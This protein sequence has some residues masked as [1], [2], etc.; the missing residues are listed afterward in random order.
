MESL[1]DKNHKKVSSI[2][3]VLFHFYY[4]FFYYNYLLF[5]LIIL[6]FL[7]NYSKKCICHTSPSPAP[8]KRLPRRGDQERADGSCTPYVPI[9]LWYWSV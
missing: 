2:L 1:I 6:W 3:L 4:A 8:P 5:I 7:I 9:A